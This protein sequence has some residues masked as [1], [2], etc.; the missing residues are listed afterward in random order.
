MSI[1]CF[2]CDRSYP[3][4]MTTAKEPGFLAQLSEALAPKRN[5]LIAAVAFVRTFRQG[6]NGTAVTAA[7]GGITL[8]ALGLAE[9][10]W[11][12]VGLAL[13]AVGIASLGAGLNAGWN[14]LENGLSP[15]YAEAVVDTIKDSGS[16]PST[17]MASA[18]T[19]AAASL[20]ENKTP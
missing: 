20:E 5:R 16:A 7:G 2:A 15:K 12:T 10:N 17:E 1:V 13:G 9:V 8:T 19:D 4:S 18:V 14:V 3:A 6:F 11:M